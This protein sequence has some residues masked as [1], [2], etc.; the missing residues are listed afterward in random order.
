MDNCAA[1]RA[2]LIQA[3]SGG[4]EFEGVDVLALNREALRQMRAHANG[5]Q[6]PYGS[7]DPRVTIGK[8]VGEPL[9][10]HGK[11]GRRTATNAGPQTSSTGSAY[12]AAT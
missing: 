1:H 5:L 9:L 2:P 8:S 3:D 4:V 12:R 6:D 10:I 11:V 7:L